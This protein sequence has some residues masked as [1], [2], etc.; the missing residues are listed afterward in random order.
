MW[1]HANRIALGAIVL[2]GFASTTVQAAPNKIGAI[3]DSISA[4]MDT[5][6]DCDTLVSCVAQFGEDRGY[7]WTTGYALSDSMRNMLGFSATVEH[8]KNGSR[9]QDAPGQA[10][11]ILN[12]GGAHTVTIELGGNDVCRDV[13]DTLPTRAE[14]AAQIRTTMSTL[15][16]ASAS[17][18]PS[19][20]LLAEVPDVVALRNTMRNQENFAF[21]TCQDLWDV[22]TDALNV[23]TC[24][25]GFFDFICDF[26]DY[27][28]EDYV[29]PLVDVMVA[30]FDVDFPCGYVLNS[31]S[32]STKRTLARSLNN[33]INSAIQAAAQ[34]WNGVNGVEVR[35]ANNVYEYQYTT[36]D[37][38]QID[39]F[40]PNRNG[41]RNLARTI[42]SGA[43]FGTRSPVQDLAAPVMASSPASSA[44]WNGSGTYRD[45]HFTF[46]TNEQSSIEVWTYN[47]DYGNW[48]FEGE[49]NETPTDHEFRMEGFNYSYYWQTH[50]RPTDRNNNTGTWY[51]TGCI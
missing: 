8:Q 28:I 46:T 34:E 23:N 39:C 4:A 27:V 32:N 2:L 35:F 6:D 19:R 51:S 22:N 44:W 5:N 38:S 1:S 37:V 16:N 20:I 11:K 12:D 42:Y 17:T 31:A 13:N 48:Y 18:R 24:D 36:G 7:S 40:H 49:T 29:A 50:V 41:Q 43:G 26:F 33:E 21:E 9:W 25:W 14:I 3:G 15:V 45:I 47:C 30:A 10:Q